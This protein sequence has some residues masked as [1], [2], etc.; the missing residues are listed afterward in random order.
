MPP[1]TLALPLSEPRLAWGA[2]GLAGAGALWTQAMAPQ[3]LAIMRFGQICSG[4]PAF[5]PHCPACY[6]AATIAGG[7]VG[8]LA[9]GIAPPR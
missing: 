3:L 2:A 8:L 4:H 6:L 1:R 7:A 5:A 9:L